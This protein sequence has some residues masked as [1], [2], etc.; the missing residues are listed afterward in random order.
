MAAFNDIRRGLAANLATLKTAGYDGQISPW[1]LENPA[2]PTISIGG[3]TSI[4]YDI[5]FQ[6]AS[7]DLT[8]D[9]LTV[10]VEAAIRKIVDVQT[11]KTLDRFHGDLSIKAAVESDPQ[12]TSRMADDGTITSG[13]T[14]ACDAL[15]V[16]GYTFQG[17]LTLPNGTQVSLASWTVEI[18]T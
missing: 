12:L 4:D 17:T 15:R 9:Q 2:P 14:A 6:G 8:G 3:I 18:I 1:L 16:T 10:E 7:Y 11:Q 13:E 5:V